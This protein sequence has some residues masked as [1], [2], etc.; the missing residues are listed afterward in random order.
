MGGVIN[1]ITKTPQEREITVQS[2]YGSYN[3][4]NNTPH[5]GTNFVTG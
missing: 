2:G 4:W 3:T 1:I 5:T